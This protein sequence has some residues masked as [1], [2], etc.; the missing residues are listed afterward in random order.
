MSCSHQ[1]RAA[2]LGC[3][4]V[5]AGWSAAPSADA[6]GGGG[7]RASGATSVRSAGGASR[8]STQGRQ[9]ATGNRA[10][11]GSISG[12]NR[13]NAGDINRG[14]RANAGN[15]NSGNRVNTGNVNTGNRVNTGNINTGNV[16][17]NVDN[18]YDWDDHYHPV[19][20]GVAFGT[21]AAVTA[22]AVG[23]MIYSLPP[24]C[25]NRIY[26]GVTYYG[27]GNVWYEPQYQ[28]DKV[29]YVVV[30]QPG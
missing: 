10:N 7:V 16:N 23:S 21:A 27:C 25:V 8:G 26:G 15:I 18:G 2:V 22:A 12:G 9:A 24:S 4:I 3:L 28:G 17:I 20:R 19:A 30:E 6:R 14:N 1:I 29:V 11:T 5:A 13:A